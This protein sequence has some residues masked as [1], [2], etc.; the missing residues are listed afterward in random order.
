MT[1]FWKTRDRA[2]R[3]F[4]HLLGWAAFLEELVKRKLQSL[5]GMVVCLELLEGRIYFFKNYFLENLVGPGLV[6]GTCKW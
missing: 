1:L 3:N 6:Q 5:Q 4:R 2:G